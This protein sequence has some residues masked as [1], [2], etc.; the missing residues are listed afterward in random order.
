MSGGD[1]VSNG[2]KLEVWVVDPCG[3]A[4]AW[5][6]GAV[7]KSGCKVYLVD[8][9]EVEKAE[10]LLELAKRLLR[11]AKPVRVYYPYLIIPV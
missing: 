11:E 4:F 5:A 10:D 1:P 3:S 8:E 2:K 7:Q 9:K 6:E